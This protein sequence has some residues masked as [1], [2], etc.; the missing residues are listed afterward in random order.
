MYLWY[1]CEPMKLVYKMCCKEE[2]ISENFKDMLLNVY[3][4]N[5]RIYHFVNNL[6]G[7]ST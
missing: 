6:P 5:Q 3:S 1:F 7:V 2:G 4:H